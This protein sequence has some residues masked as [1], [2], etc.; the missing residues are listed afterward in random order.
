MNLNKSDKIPTPELVK[1]RFKEIQKCW[2][3]YRE[4][5]ADRFD[6]EF[7]DGLSLSA[8][9]IQHSVALDALIERV[10]HQV[11]I[12]GMEYWLGPK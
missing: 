12:R 6:R 11:N 10:T 4:K 7:R 1:L 9:D 3:L 5:N 8:E 2:L